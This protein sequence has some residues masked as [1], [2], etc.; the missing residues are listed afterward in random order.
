M[1]A[2]VADRVARHQARTGATRPMAK[3]VRGPVEQF[4][5]VAVAG[6]EPS[7][8]PQHGQPFAVALGWL[9]QDERHCVPG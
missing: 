6:F 1:E 2:F 4:L 3:E 5:S 9:L 7:G 8:R